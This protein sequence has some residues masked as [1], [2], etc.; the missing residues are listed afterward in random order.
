MSYVFA[1]FHIR[2]LAILGL[3]AITTATSASQ[4]SADNNP[5]EKG[6]IVHALTGLSFPLK[7]S[8]Y[9]RRKGLHFFADDGTDVSAGYVFESADSPMTSEIT[10][11]VTQIP[12]LESVEPYARDAVH[13]IL[14][15]FKLEGPHGY[16]EMEGAGSRPAGYH[17]HTYMNYRDQPVVTGVWV[18]KVGDWFLKVRYTHQLTPESVQILKDQEKILAMLEKEGGMDVSGINF[19]IRD[20]FGFPV[21]VKQA[22]AFISKFDWSLPKISPQQD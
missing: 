18:A 21:G 15:R 2:M 5:D 12:D 20:D 11:Y 13:Q 4:E 17:S 3:I 9:V 7:Q 22:G 1:G 8:G 16:G 14:R 19:D 6:D 10:V